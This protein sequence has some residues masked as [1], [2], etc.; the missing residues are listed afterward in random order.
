MIEQLD[1]RE[2]SHWIEDKKPFR[3]LD[4]RFSDEKIMADIGG[5]LIPLPELEQRW[6]EIPHGEGPLVVY[7]HHGVRSLHA[8][9]FL[10]A[11]GIQALNLRG[12][13]DQWSLQV[14]PKVPRY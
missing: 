5:P 9:H 4:V 7:C 10:K 11:H 8:C 6:Q 13:I 2:L 3:L 1:V 14:D 12:G